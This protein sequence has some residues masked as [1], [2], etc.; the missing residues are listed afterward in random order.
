[1]KKAREILKSED[2]KRIICIDVDNWEEIFNYVN[3]DD[4]LKTRRGKYAERNASFIPMLHR[5]D[6]SIVQDIFVNVKGKRNTIQIRADILN[7]GNMLND[8]WGV[9][10]RATNPQIL[11]FQSVVNNQPTYRLAT[12]RFTDGTTGLITNTYSKNASVLDVWTAQLGIRY[13]FGK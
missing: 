5:F 4:Y 11:A 8:N 13:I 7:F 9:S 12:E 6:L 10:Q 3:Q 2:S 1:M